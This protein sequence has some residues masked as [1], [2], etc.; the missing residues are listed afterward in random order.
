MRIQPLE[1]AGFEEIK[2]AFPAM[3][4]ERIG[5]LI[6]QPIFVGTYGLRIAD[7]AARTPAD[8]I[9]SYG[10]CGRGRLDVLR[11]ESFS[12][13]AARC[14]LRRQNPERYQAG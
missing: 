10:V 8:D 12:L 1:A 13:V 7:L 5:G 11:A 9:G 14:H 4:R 6:V 2:G 3:I